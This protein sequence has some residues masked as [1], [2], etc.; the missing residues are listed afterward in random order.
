[1]VGGN[2]FFAVS[3][4]KSNWN[5]DWQTEASVRDLGGMISVSVCT[6]VIVGFITASVASASERI[7]F[8]QNIRPILAAHCFHCHGPDEAESGL[9]LDA[10][11]GV[12]QE[13]T[14]ALILDSYRHFALKRM[15]KALYGS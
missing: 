13:E 5:G 12:I 10:E 14:E 6:L 9:R 15:L 1:M 2:L 4:L 8:N 11:D 7:D 3:R